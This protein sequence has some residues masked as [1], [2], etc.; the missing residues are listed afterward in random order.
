MEE[1]EEEEEREKGLDSRLDSLDRMLFLGSGLDEIVVDEECDVVEVREWKL[2]GVVVG[3]GR[4]GGVHCYKESDGN[5]VVKDIIFG[6]GEKKYRFCK[7]ISKQRGPSLSD[8]LI[9]N[10]KHFILIRNPLS[11]LPSFDKVVPPSFLELGL[12]DLVSIYSNLCELGKP[13]AVI[14][15]SEL[16][17]NPE[18]RKDAT[19]VVANLQRQEVQSRLIACDYL[20]ANIELGM[21]TQCD[22]KMPDFVFCET[23][24][25][26]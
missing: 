7:H 25:V 6:P 15:A 14:D 18:A 26:Y 19:Q 1:E 13:P 4:Y 12:G 17:E 10:G 5:K 20:G 24:T 22:E 3:G 2:G 21:K 11:I 16:Q 23:R 9:K 8:D